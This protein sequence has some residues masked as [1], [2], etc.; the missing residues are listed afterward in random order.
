MMMKMMRRA[1]MMMMERNE[2]LDVKTICEN[3]QNGDFRTN[4]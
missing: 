2:I 4:S 1:V 3:Q